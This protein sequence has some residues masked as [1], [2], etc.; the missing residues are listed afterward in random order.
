MT[1][2]RQQAFNLLS[3]PKP[4]GLNR[5]DKVGAVR[6]AWRPVHRRVESAYQRRLRA[7]TP[8]HSSY[9][10]ALYTCLPFTAFK[11]SGIFFWMF[12]STLTSCLIFIARF[13]ESQSNP[14][15]FVPAEK[16]FYMFVPLHSFVTD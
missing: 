16:L 6:H 9:F 2:H 8:R 1:Q 5:H 10:S 4:A 13:S 11:T 7:H 14:D 12:D 3:L 15:Y